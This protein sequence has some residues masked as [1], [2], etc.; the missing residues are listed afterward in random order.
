MK[1]TIILS[2]TLFINSYSQEQRSSSV[3]ICTSLTDNQIE[4]KLELSD[5]GLGSLKDQDD[6]NGGIKFKL[7]G[8]E[9][10]TQSIKN[11][12]GAMKIQ[13][14][15]ELISLFDS[16]QQYFE[17]TQSKIL[18]VQ[19]GGR[20]ANAWIVL[21]PLP[22][23]IRPEAGESHSQ[24]YPRYALKCILDS[25]PTTLN[26]THKKTSKDFMLDDFSFTVKNLGKTSKC[27]QNTVQV[28][29]NSKINN[30]DYNTLL[31]FITKELTG[32]NIPS[33]LINLLVKP[34]QMRDDM[35]DEYLIKLYENWLK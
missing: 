11:I 5:Q 28:S 2:L 23:H 17:M 29:Y 12:P 21:R 8:A 14:V 25:S 32:A 6:K 1:I 22:R 30:K 24:F 35:M 4:K 19:N 7:K 16:P 15:K 18:N 3:K 13:K 26:C 34:E 10:I 20:E 33:E 31:E 27:S 9:S